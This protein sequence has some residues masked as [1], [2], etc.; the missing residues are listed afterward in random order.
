GT[1][2]IPR[3]AGAAPVGRV[4]AARGTGA[5]DPAGPAAVAAGRALRQSGRARR[6]TRRTGDRGASG[7]W[8]RGRGGDA[9]IRAASSRRA[10]PVAGGGMIAL[11]RHEFAAVLRGAASW[12]FAPAFFLLFCTLSVFALGYD[13]SLGPMGP[14]LV[15]LAAV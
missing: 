1:Y 6:G 7:A 9:R 8:R 4:A 3:H 15:W 11:S 5:A 10:N 14:A 13:E 12:A 2:P